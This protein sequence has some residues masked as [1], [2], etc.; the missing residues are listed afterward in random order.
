ML[1]LFKQLG[2]RRDAAPGT[3]EYLGRSRSFTPSL[4]HLAYGPE[5]LEERVLD[6]AG[7]APVLDFGR[8]HFLSLVGVH[9][10]EVVRRV[11]GWF[12]LHPLILEDVVSG[13]QR[14]KL[15]D[16]GDARFVTLRNV[17]YQQGD[18]RLEEEQ[19]S[20]LWG[21]N[22]VLAFQESEDDAWAG[23]LARLRKGAPR[24]RAGGPQYLAVALFDALVDGA[25]DALGMLSAEVE[26]LESRLAGRH[27]EEGLL[28]AYRIR[29][30]C[31]LLLRN[32]LLPTQE[33]LG[34]LKRGE[35][36]E[37]TGEAAPYLEDVAEHALHAVEAAKV[38]HDVL[39]GIMDAHISLAGMRMNNVMRVLTVVATIFIPLTFV[40]GIYGMN[41]EFMPELKWRFG[42]FLCLGAMAVIGVGMLVYFA[43]KRWL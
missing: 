2:L 7:E 25:M 31:I 14:P 6:T 21:E 19:V 33:V 42:Y 35:A 8:T 12:G 28:E 27:E 5:G 43:R 11:G 39:G 17:I 40:A 22:Y 36:E 32:V 34:A 23:V 1:D 3:L 18:K 41:F 13:A 37:I 9:E 38:L 26:E 4:T 30:D 24:I 20:V 15:N 10:P 29:R 16:Q